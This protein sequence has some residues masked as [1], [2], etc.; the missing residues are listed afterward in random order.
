MWE[1]FASTQVAARP[2]WP[3]LIEPLKRDPGFRISVT[4][5]RQALQK[6]VDHAVASGSTQFIAAGGDGCVHLVTN[7][8]LR[9]KWS[10]PP[11]IATIPLGTGSD[12]ARHFQI[13]LVPTEAFDI[14]RRRYSG[15]RMGH[16]V[17]RQRGLY[18]AY[19]RRRANSGVDAAIGGSPVLPCLGVGITFLPPAANHRPFRR[20]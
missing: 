15:R 5:S 1:V 13:P 3:S 17:L 11:T 6:V 14:I 7:A 18:R 2:N 9:H 20:R 19:G 10:S 8:I 12:F 16:A 4:E